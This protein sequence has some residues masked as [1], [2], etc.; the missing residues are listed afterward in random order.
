MI[1]YADKLIAISILLLMILSGQTAVFAQDTPALSLRLSRGFG[2]S[3]GI[4]ISGTFSYRISGPD[5][6]NRVE[7]FMDDQLIGTDTEA[8]FRL[9]FRTSSHDI[10]V[11]T[12]YAKGYLTDGTELISNQI[13]REFISGSDSL[14]RTLLIIVP[15]LVISLGDG[16][17]RCVLQIATANRL[18]NRPLMAHSMVPSALH[19]I[20]HLPSIC[21]ACAS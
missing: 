19:V 10:G 6:L 12:L 18:A 8:P 17:L 11:H 7:F 15:I 1:K 2:S 13:K 4:R 9:Q 3:T 14:N 16:G 5:N 21:G 20:N